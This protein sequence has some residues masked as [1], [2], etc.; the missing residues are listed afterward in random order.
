[1]NEL[2][3]TLRNIREEILGKLIAIPGDIPVGRV[4]RVD[5]NGA[6]FKDGARI[7]IQG[8]VFYH[9]INESYQT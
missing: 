2:E 8:L 6:W 7:A 1:M 5:E 3:Q 9:P 4:I